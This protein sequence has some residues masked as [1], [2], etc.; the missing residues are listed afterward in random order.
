MRG[1]D[2][3]PPSPSKRKEATAVQCDKHVTLSP[4]DSCDTITPMRKRL[5]WLLIA[6]LPV[7][8]AALGWWVLPWCVALPESLLQPRAPSLVYTASDG[9]PLRQLLTANGPLTCEGD[10]VGTVRVVGGGEPWFPSEFFGR[11]DIYYSNR[12]F[13]AFE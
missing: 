9:T 13:V 6:T 2:S 4:P 7:L 12:G 11:Y 3:G 5:R 1:H 10:D 8:C